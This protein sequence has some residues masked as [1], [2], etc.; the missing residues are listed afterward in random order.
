VRRTPAIVTGLAALAI[1]P[2]L[3]QEAPDQ[4]SHD[5]AQ[6]HAV[7]MTPGM[8][9]SSGG[10]MHMMEMMSHCI[11]VMENM[12]FDAHGEMGMGHDGQMVPWDDGWRNDGWPDDGR[13]RNER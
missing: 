5:F 8:M 10:M 7:P 11:S 1:T 13:P 6:E 3:A 12:H 2:V 9:G 4:P